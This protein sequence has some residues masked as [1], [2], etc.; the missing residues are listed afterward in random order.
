MAT[1]PA[2]S[3]FSYKKQ[4]IVKQAAIHN[5]SR[6][7]A[8][9]KKAERITTPSGFA[10]RAKMVMELEMVALSAR[11]V[12]LEELSTMTD[13]EKM[14]C[15]FKILDKNRDGSLSVVELADGM[16]KIN[17]DVGFEESLTLAMERVA[18]FDTDGD[19]M[20]QYSEFKE[21]VTQLAKGF[22]ATFHDLAEMLILSV[23]FSE[24]GND[25][26][27]SM[28]AEIADET[29]TE[30]LLEE[31]AL[32]K[33]MADDRTRVLFHLFDLDADGHV[34]FCE[35]VLGMDKIT[36]NLDATA[37]TEALFV[38]ERDENHELNYQEFT[39]F[40]VK[41][42]SATGFTFDEVV[43]KMT[44][45]AADDH[46]RTIKRGDLMMKLHKRGNG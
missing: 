9:T 22:G 33:V 30:A 31:G 38:C 46:P 37:V 1:T 4:K 41:L 34:D 5:A 39:R 13:E 3:S 44:K 2:P 35:V 17:G 11:L 20:L 25:E 42:I 16:R 14:D 32:A 19:A 23:V 36:E 28:K 43:F 21:Y 10:E 40:L 18:S 6:M 15:L 29:I 26:L 27:E 24:T 8:S 45:A 12:L 7:A